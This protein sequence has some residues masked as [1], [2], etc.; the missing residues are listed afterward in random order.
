MSGNWFYGKRGALHVNRSG[1]RILPS[2]QRGGPMPAAAAG[3]GQTGGAQPVGA[4]GGLGGPPIEAKDFRNT[5]R[6]INGDTPLHARNFL[7]CIKS[8]QKPN[9]DIEIGFYSTLPCLLALMAIQQGRS[10]VWDGQT[11]KPA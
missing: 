8:R 2:A 11:A 10:I 3:R 7:D 4:P 1:Y 6:G 5:D 9:C